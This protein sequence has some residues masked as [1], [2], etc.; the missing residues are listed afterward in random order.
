MKNLHEKGFYDINKESFSKKGE[1]D[2][3]KN[4]WEYKN[5]SRVSDGNEADSSE[6][7]PVALE[8]KLNGIHGGKNAGRAC[9]IVAGT[10]CGGTIQGTFARKFNT[11]ENC[12]FYKLVRQEEHPGFVLSA[13]LL[14][15]LK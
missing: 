6:T 10:F 4:C 14:S 3:K 7:C 2:M 8:S 15:M 12:D 11:C 1:T 9:W 13:N 5:C